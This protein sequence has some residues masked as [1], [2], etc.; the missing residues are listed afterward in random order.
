MALAITL[1]EF[2]DSHPLHYAVLKH[3]HTD[4]SLHSAVASHLPGDSVAKSVLLK[5]EDG[6]MLAVLP[7]SHRLDLG[8]IHQFLKHHVGLATEDE[9]NHVFQD[10]ELGAIPPTG[11]MYDLDTIVD[12]ALLS[13]SDIYFEAGDHELMIHMQLPEFT[14][15]LGDATLLPI[16][17]HI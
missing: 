8:R 2:L 10:C 14:K 17:H 11:L 9:V 3:D 15:L 13:Q 1:Q 16:S 4:T 7:A 6:Y 5:H 12:E